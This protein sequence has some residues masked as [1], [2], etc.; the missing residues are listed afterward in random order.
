MGSTQT[1]IHVSCQLQPLL[2]TP[3]IKNDNKCH[4]EDDFWDVALYRLVGMYI[5]FKT[6]IG[7]ITYETR[8]MGH[9]YRVSQK[10]HRLQFTH[11]RIKKVNYR[12]VY[13]LLCWLPYTHECSKCPQPEQ[14][15]CLQYS[16]T[17]TYFSHCCWRNSST[18]TLLYAKSCHLVLTDAHL[19]LASLYYT[20]AE[21]NYSV[22]IFVCFI[23][24]RIVYTFFRD[25][26]YII[27]Q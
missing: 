24:T 3:V 21:Y 10:I 20:T 7:P 18:A 2:K 26:L 15:H 12:D 19:H 1:S 25:T 27:K 17:V 8:L 16:A 6:L 22:F 11:I 13:P 4:R 23:N 5:L 14:M 9:R